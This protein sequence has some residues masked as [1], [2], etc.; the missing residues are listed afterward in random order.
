MLKEAMPKVPLPID[1]AIPEIL[2]KLHNHGALVLSA[3][4]GTGK[5]TRLPAALMKEFGGSVLVL[6]PRRIAAT[7]ACQR[8]AAEN[9]YALGKEVGYQVR[10]E[11]QS[12]KETRLL[13]LTEALLLRKLVNDPLLKGVACVVLDEFHE[14]SL[15]VDVALA[16][17]KELQE[18]ERPELKIVVMSAT[19][20][21]EPL[22]KYLGDAPVVK[23]PGQLYPL[24]IRYESKPQLLQ[25]NFEFAERIRKLIQRAFEENP[26]GDILVFLPGRG[27]IEKQNSLLHEWADARQ[28]Q[29]CQLH[30]QLTLAQQRQAIETIP[31]RRKII[32]ATNIAESSLTVE[33]VRIVVDSGLARNMEI[34]PRTGFDSMVLQRISKAS[35]KQRAGRAARLGAGVVYRAWMPFDELSMREFILPEIA[36][37][38]LSETILLLSALG[39]TKPKTFS[40]FEKPGDRALEQAE[41]FLVSIEAIEVDGS[42]TSVGESLQ[43]IPLHPRLA[44]L[45]LLGKA[46][47]LGRLACELAAILSEGISRFSQRSWQSEN[48]LWSCWKYWQ[49]RRQD[50]QFHSLERVVQ[51]L[52]S[53]ISVRENSSADPDLEKKSVHLL[54]AA[55][56]DRLCRRRKPNEARA[57]MSGGR[58][59]RLHE[60]SN[61]QTSDFFLAIELKEGRDSAEAL[62]FEAV[63]VSDEM[64]RE[65]LL[66]RADSF[67][68][69]EWDEGKERFWIL[70]TKRWKGL[71]VAGEHR[72][73]AKSE[74]IELALAKIAA[75]RWELA[76]VKNEGFRHWL[77]RLQY[78]AKAKEYPLLNTEQIRAAME[79]ACFGENS[80]AAIWDKNILPYFE[81]QLDLEHLQA[82]EKYCP[83]AWTVPSGSR[84][85]I[86]Y[87]EE[88]GPSVEVR[89]QELFG[90]AQSPRVGDQ[91]LTLILLAPNFIPVQVTRDL[92]SFWKN[93]YGEV[94]K[95]LRLRYPRHSWPEDPSTALPQAKGRGRAL[96][97][98]FSG[99][100]I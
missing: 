27:E 22:A 55:Y 87:S 67:S 2:E 66:P 46:M 4:P 33:G 9:G 31:A 13:F 12:S 54:L 82:L 69:L 41:Q 96:G 63:G 99:T 1:A 86:Q 75:D 21:A 78:L 73:P 44:K 38:D 80:L 7:A 23:V 64:V 90:L 19:L 100:S 25:T 51:Q 89:L 92:E 10:F 11:N 70:E 62:V 65:S 6:E 17:L 91:A 60:D 32:L 47:G 30:G 74:E 68:E 58:G 3:E 15:S 8:I 57:V 29:L 56:P 77:A 81:S 24:D 85:R 45:I 18:L 59:V 14:R 39:I 26:K 79:L 48:D 5:T 52:Q 36:R 20:S 97:A 42:L 50:R 76:A 61:V 98:N 40:W 71:S 93:T 84:I 28:V 43:N 34:H 37:S 88:K 72:R 35:A 16:A 53:L 94:R 83:E 49:E 95:E